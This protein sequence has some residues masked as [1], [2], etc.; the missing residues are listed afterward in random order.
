VCTRLL[1]DDAGIMT[2]NCSDTGSET[3]HVASGVFFFCLT[4]KRI[5]KSAPVH[6]EVLM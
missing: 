5:Y 6:L 1:M 3:G 2:R 4:V